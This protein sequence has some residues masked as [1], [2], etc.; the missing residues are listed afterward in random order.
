[1]MTRKVMASK[2]IKSSNYNYDRCKRKSLPV[3][4]TD[5]FIYGLIAFHFAPMKRKI[6]NEKVF[7]QKIIGRN[8]CHY[9]ED[10]YVFYVDNLLKVIRCI[11]NR[12]ITV[13]KLIFR[14]GGG[15]LE[16]EG[17]KEDTANI[18]LKTIMINFLEVLLRSPR[19]NDRMVTNHQPL[20]IFTNHPIIC[21]LLHFLISNYFNNYYRPDKENNDGYWLNRKIILHYV[22][23]FRWHE[24]IEKMPFIDFR[25]QRYYLKTRTVRVPLYPKGD[26]DGDGDSNRNRDRDPDRDFSPAFKYYN[27][28]HYHHYPPNEKKKNYLF[29][30]QAIVIKDSN[31]PG[32]KSQVRIFIPRK[33]INNKYFSGGSIKEDEYFVHEDFFYKMNKGLK[34]YFQS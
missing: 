33:Y 22:M 15:D 34:K 30:D 25:R 16:I 24:M 23:D 5:L 31:T 1:M 18:T 7:D 6:N 32:C 26:G 8:Y 21:E 9:D 14:H 29:K 13:K 11:S 10:S 12:A 17:E 20:N 28:H 4:P 3:A 19:D 2:I 27:Y